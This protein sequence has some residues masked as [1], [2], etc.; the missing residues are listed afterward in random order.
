VG[1]ATPAQ[2]RTV[3]SARVVSGRCDTGSAANRRCWCGEGTAG[4]R[5]G[6]GIRPPTCWSPFRPILGPGDVTTVPSPSA[7]NRWQFWLLTWSAGFLDSHTCHIN[8]LGN[9]EIPLLRAGLLLTDLSTQEANSP[10]AGGAGV[11]EVVE[12]AGP[13]GRCGERIPA[14]R[15][16]VAVIA[17]VR[18][19]VRSQPILGRGLP[20]PSRPSQLPQP[21][22]PVGILAAGRVVGTSPTVTPVTSTPLVAAK[23]LSHVLMSL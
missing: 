7:V 22:R 9:D 6:V 4:R 13:G 14:H 3:G 16:T 5:R 17:L 1:G 21:Y 23:S 8:T 18:P 2:R 12:E 20:Q 11:T 15:R 10:R 19:G